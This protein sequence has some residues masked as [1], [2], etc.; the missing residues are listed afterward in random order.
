MKVVPEE[1]LN[2]LYAFR[3]RVYVHFFFWL[4]LVSEKGGNLSLLLR[5]F[6]ELNVR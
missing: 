6:N 3:N 4:S 5:K 1:I 2:G